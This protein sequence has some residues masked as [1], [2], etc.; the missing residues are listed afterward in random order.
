MSG[1]D[2]WMQNESGVIMNL[3]ARRTGLMLSLGGDAVVISRAQWRSGCEACKASGGHS[4]RYSFLPALCLGSALLALTCGPAV[5]DQRHVRDTIPAAEAIVDGRNAQYVVRFD[6][7]VDHASAK[8]EIT[9][10]SGKVVASLP[11]LLDS[12]PNVLF[13]S[14]P[15]LPPGRYKLHWHFGAGAGANATDGEVAFSVRP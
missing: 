8:L 13:G 3:K 4:M 2:L 12:S 7:P 11:V 15:A 9:Q 14:G 1:G 5:A 10:D 6:G